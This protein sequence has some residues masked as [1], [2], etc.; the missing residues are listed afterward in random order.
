[1]TVPCP[2]RH[3][4]VQ[5]LTGLR[6]DPFLAD[7]LNDEPV[8]R[9]RLPHGDGDTWVVTR[10]HDVKFVT[11][12]PRFSRAA[13]PGASFSKM[14]RHAVPLDQAVS[15]ADPPEHARIR[16]VVGKAFAKSTVD[17]LRPEAEQRVHD[18]ID[19][20]VRDGAPGELVRRV[21][22]PFPVAMI[23]T[24]LGVPP[25]DWPLTV[26]WAQTVLSVARDQ[27]A[28]DRAVAAKAAVGA[29]FRDL[30]A[31]RRAEP[32]DDLLTTLVSAQDEGIINEA[33]M[34]ALTVLLQSN[35]WHAVRNNSSMMVYTLLTHPRLWDRLRAEPAAAP[36]VVEELLRFIP[37][38]SGLGQPRIATE[39][40][41]VGGVLVRA[42]EAVYVSY[43]TANRDERV[44]PDPERIDIDRPDVPH[45]AFGYGPHYC[46]APALAR[47]ESEVLLTALV[48]RL[49]EL[50]LAVPVEQV[51]WPTGCLIRGPVELPVTW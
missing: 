13:V 44:F 7:L 12:D 20:M 32:R 26:D 2:V 1:M 50:R 19:A 16:G 46:M 22:S 24:V 29:Y 11:S 49:P 21:T 10:Y 41:E 35:G 34:L 30:A 8:A 42:G 14:T 48:R 25:E 40:V 36:R 27:Q 17:G 51:P 33:E 37:H 15:F 31:Q 9:V 28:A 3:Y 5:D 38:K 4:E 43:L 18:L 47:M 6:F 39:D 45:L 23:G